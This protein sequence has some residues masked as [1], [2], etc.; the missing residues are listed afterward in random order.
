MVGKSCLYKAPTLKH[1][2]Q[3]TDIF[4]NTYTIHL[5]EQQFLARDL[6]S[7]DKEKRLFRKL[8][9]QFKT[10]ILSTKLICLV[11][12]NMLILLNLLKN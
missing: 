10:N 4:M 7:L 8:L 9:R 6:Y 2:L 5:R 12:T 1:T 3:N 11:K